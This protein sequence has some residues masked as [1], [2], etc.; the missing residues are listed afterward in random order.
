MMYIAI[1]HI[2][3]NTLKQSCLQFTT[4]TDARS[5]AIRPTKQI[6]WLKENKQT[7]KLCLKSLLAFRLALSIV[8]LKKETKFSLFIIFFFK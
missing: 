6:E 7:F 2:S 8:L 1:L 4:F 3:S 5:K